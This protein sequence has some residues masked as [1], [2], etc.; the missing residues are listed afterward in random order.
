MSRYKERKKVVA[1]KIKRQKL[2][3]QRRVFGDVVLGLILAIFLV[4]LFFVSPVFQIQVVKVSS[5][6]EIPASLVQE[7]IKTEMN[8][9]VFIFFPGNSFWLTAKRTIEQ[10][11]SRSFP[12]AKT[13][14][15]KKIFP[16]SLSVEVKKREPFF[17]WCPEQSENCFLADEDRIVFVE[18][19]TEK[20]TDGL[21]VVS[22]KK[23]PPKIFDEFCSADTASKILAVRNSLS[24]QGIEVK[25]FI[26]EEPSLIT[27]R[28]MEGWEAYFDLTSNIDLTLE[29]LRLLLEK[30]LPQPQRKN[31]QYIDLRFSKAYYK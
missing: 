8:K 4:Y 21:V 24:K 25:E 28:T 14:Q 1:R 10:E 2:F 5:P 19:Q 20:I 16:H 18:A 17:A 26:L 9:K 22:A 31:L 27:T 13:V 11:I 29:K 12:L 6:N 30:E 15:L 3:F 7:A 23:E